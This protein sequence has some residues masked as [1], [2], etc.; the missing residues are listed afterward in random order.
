MALTTKTYPLNPQRTGMA[1]MVDGISYSAIGGDH[2]VLTLLKPWE[3]AARY[4]L[5]V[6]VQGSGW[7][8]PDRGYEIPQLAHLAQRGFV[9]ATVC[10]RDA[11]QGHPFPAFLQDVKTA[12]RFLRFNAEKYS[13]DPARVCIYGTSS[14]GNT[15]LL[16]G[17]TGDEPRYET[18]EYKG[19]SDAVGCVA[20]CFGPTDLALITDHMDPL[21]PL[22]ISL[23]GNRD[24]KEVMRE[25]SPLY[26]LGKDKPYPPC[27]IAHGTGDDVVPYFMATKMAKKLAAL[28]NE[29]RLL[30]VTD[31]PHEDTFWS[32]PLIEDI[33]AFI[34]TH[35]A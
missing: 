19:V 16:V 10:H 7:T 18:E 9:V 24:P 21:D 13:I 32:W 4:P 14:G 25:M 8:T 6:F 15:A 26:A 1:R 17:A 23:S 2:T 3:E 11:R 27:L 35:T 33:Y 29:V 30:T 28:G 20:A 31:A 34:Q 5:V 22:F 12:I